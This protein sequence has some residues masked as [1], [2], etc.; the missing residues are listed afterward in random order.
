V[1]SKA[2]Y[3]PAAKSQGAEE[4][5]RRITKNPERKNRNRAD[6]RTV[7]AV[8]FGLLIFCRTIFSKR[9]APFQRFV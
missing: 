7:P 4:C 8:D 5:D 6:A 2:G 3:F 1:R 9:N